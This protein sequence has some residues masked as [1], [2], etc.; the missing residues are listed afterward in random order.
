MERVPPPKGLQSDPGP[1]HW[2]LMSQ[3]R[4]SLFVPDI[5]G[6]RK[7]APHMPTGSYSHL[8]RQL[9]QPLPLRA[10]GSSAVGCY[11]GRA[12]GLGR[13]LTGIL[14]AHHMQTRYVSGMSTRAKAAS[15]SLSL[16]SLTSLSIPPLSPDALL[17]SL[18]TEH[19]FF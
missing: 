19:F 6:D 8:K 2:G 3:T 15:L 17:Y 18:F 12:V 11:I 10:L 13:L 14:T 7:S 4:M 5:L 16:S 1:S 9:I